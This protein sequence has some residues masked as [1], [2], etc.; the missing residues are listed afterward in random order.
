MISIAFSTKQEAGYPDRGGDHQVWDGVI[1]KQSKF[2]KGKV[3]S[4]RDE[5]KKHDDNRNVSFS[6]FF[7]VLLSWL[8]NSSNI[9]LFHPGAKFY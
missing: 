7:L 2:F 3:S 8:P 4:S 5:L 6:I 9:I 1:R